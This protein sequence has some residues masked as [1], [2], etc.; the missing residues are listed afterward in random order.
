MARSSPGAWI[1]AAA[2]LLLACA[3]PAQVGGSGFGLPK[4]GA[5]AAQTPR[6]PSAS[7]E[8]VQV[9][10]SQSATTIAP[11]ATVDVAIAFTIPAGWHIWVHETQAR[12]L[13]GVAVFEG[14]LF[15]TLSLASET[16]GLRIS[17]IQWPTPHT[18]EAD[19]GEGPL[20]YAVYEGSGT[21]F[22]RLQ[23][24]PETSGD[25]VTEL[26]LSLQACNAT[27]CIQPGDIKIPI[28]VRVQAGVAA[29][30]AAGPAFAGLDPTRMVAASIVEDGGLSDASDGAIRFDFFGA[31]F[32]VDPRG[33][34]LL[35]VLLVA[36]LGGAL[37]NFTPCVLPVIPLKIMSLSAAAGDRARCLRLGLV[38]SAGVVAFWLG[39][40]V[41]VGGI[42]GFT[43]A[44]QLFQYPAFTIAL[45]LFIAVM[46]VGMAGFFSVNL[47]Q[48]V[49]GIEASHE[50]AGG[51]FVMGV[52]TAVLSTPCTAPLMGAAAGWAASS[53]SMPTVLA[54]FGTIGAGMA[55]PYLLLSAYPN[56]ARSMPR[57]GPASEVV[58]QVMGLLLLAAAAFFVGA[59]LN[60]LRAAPGPEHWWLVGA[61]G[62]AAGLWLAWRTVRLARQFATRLVF[63]SLGL[64]IAVLSV[65]ISRAL[66]VESVGWIPYS[67][68]TLAK[69]KADGKVVVLD[70]TAEWCLNCKALESAVLHRA[71]V[72][73]ALAV[74][75]VVAIKVDITNRRSDGWN[76]LH[77]YDRVSI[78][79]LVV[80]SPDGK[81]VLKS[82]AYT[83]DQVLNALKQVAP[84]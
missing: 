10:A 48:W 1:G 82:D 47:P 16:S 40:G 43:A 45:G 42:S 34:G 11:G 17:G 38:M 81:V 29:T 2:A 73:D 15:T 62:A 9:S 18:A 67:A 26:V 74:P 55:A 72:V 75:E 28:R 80:Q 6:E 19:I 53:G 46:A 77:A 66:G 44:N 59:G 24:S 22:A 35:L 69:A 71:D 83:P 54:V 5:P 64:L 12:A 13:P 56:L 78:P 25:V 58:K 32:D 4:T 57:S 39:L 31:N 33:T 30:T 76:L 8:L 27:N 37:L 49:H 52:M 51:S 36:F 7:S 3:A 60:G 68:E 23:A 79:L 50:T 84:R 63:V 70:F 14:A 20:L 41:L 65:G 61:I 21:I